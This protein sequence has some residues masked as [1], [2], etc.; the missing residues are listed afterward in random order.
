MNDE[1]IVRTP[2]ERFN[3]LP[4]W[5]YQPNYIDDLPGYEGLRMHY[6]DEGPKD[7][8][9]FL[10]I[11]GEPTWGYLFRKMAPVFLDAGHRFVAPDFLGF[12]RSDKPVDDAVYTFD[13]HRNFLLAFIERLDL[14]NICL[15]IQ[16]WGGILG[17]TLPHALP[18]RISRMIIM[19]TVLPTGEDPSPGFAN[20]R[21][22]V[23]QTP[24]IDVGPLMFNAVTDIS[25]EEIEAFAKENPDAGL[26]EALSLGKPILSEAEAAAYGAPFVDISYKAGVRRFPEMVM[27]NDNGAPLNEVSGAGVPHAKEARKYLSEQWNG[28]SF[29]AIGMKDPVLIPEIQYEL[30]DMI[31]DCP[32]PMLLPTAGHFV[33]ESGEPIAKAALE[34]F[35]MT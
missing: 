10:C 29:M 6:A 3:N 7:G 5:P 30:N 17:L 12:G 32:E 35:G 4:G 8:V 27:F 1:E 34:A 19:D 14:K 24:D 28:D 20:W 13:Y 11:H 18:D 9:T 16:D 22:M 33:Q 26:A 2:E 25:D 15:V 23:R 31:K 21:E